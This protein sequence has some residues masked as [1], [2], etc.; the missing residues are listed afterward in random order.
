[1]CDVR[2]EDRFSAEKR[3]SLMRCLPDRGLQ[4]FGHLVRM[5]ENAFCSKCRIFKVSG[6]FLGLPVEDLGKHGM[7]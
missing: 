1:M 5:E 3:K 2:S 4:W 7:R 6:S